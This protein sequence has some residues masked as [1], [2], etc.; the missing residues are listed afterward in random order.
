MLHSQS[1][2]YIYSFSNPNKNIS[3]KTS[4]L[5]RRQRQRKNK[6]KASSRKI[7]NN[8]VFVLIFKVRAALKVQFSNNNAH[9][10]KDKIR[11]IPNSPHAIIAPSIKYKSTLS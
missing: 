6:S 7:A 9:I 11:D 5:V 4:I 10:E 8:S 1:L 2:K 3:I